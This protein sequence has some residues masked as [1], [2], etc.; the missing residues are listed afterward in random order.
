MDM[1]AWRNRFLQDL[2][3]SD[4]RKA[5]YMQTEQK[6]KQAL[7]EARI[8]REGSS[9]E[10]DRIIRFYEHR[11]VPVGKEPPGIDHAIRAMVNLNFLLHTKKGVF[12]KNRFEKDLH[13]I[14]DDLGVFLV[15]PDDLSGQE[16][17]YEE[18]CNVA[19]KYIQLCREDRQYNQVLLGFGK[20]K[21]ATQSKK[22]ARDLV[23]LTYFVPRETGTEKEFAMLANA[24]KNIFL[25]EFSETASDFDDALAELNDA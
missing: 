21:P 23:H 15:E 1:N 17:L 25:E 20:I 6:D 8:A 7:I 9:E 19:R 13:Q 14:L 11:Y 18:L 4:W 24:A 3:G 22:V 2:A 5:Y 10:L 12:Q 16:L